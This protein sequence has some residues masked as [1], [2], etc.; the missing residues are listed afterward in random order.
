MQRVIQER[1]QHEQERDKALAD[2][3]SS[4]IANKILTGLASML[5]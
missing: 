2:Y 4:E 1:W 5:R 3:L